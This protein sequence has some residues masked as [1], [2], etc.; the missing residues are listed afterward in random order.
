MLLKKG[1]DINARDVRGKSPLDHAA[2][3]ENWDMVSLIEQYIKP[4]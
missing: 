3:Q 2:I 4:R 1:A